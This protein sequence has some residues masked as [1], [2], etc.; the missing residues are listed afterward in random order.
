MNFRCRTIEA[1]SVRI[2]SSVYID[3]IT[4][5]LQMQ[6][7]SWGSHHKGFHR[8]RFQLLK[9]TVAESQISEGTEARAAPCEASYTLDRMHIVHPV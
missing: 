5:N 3:V 9:K 1:K 8:R 6:R 4:I 7:F 2:K